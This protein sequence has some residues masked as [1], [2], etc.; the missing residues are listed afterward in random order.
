MSIL[1]LKEY[2]QRY[3]NLYVIYHIRFGFIIRTKRLGDLVG[4][5]VPADFDAMHAMFAACE[6]LGVTCVD[7][8][9]W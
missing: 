4:K 3:P 7:N 2:K 6:R 5:F 8:T 1:K 9:Q